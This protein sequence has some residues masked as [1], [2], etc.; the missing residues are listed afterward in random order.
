MIKYQYELIVRAV[1]KFVRDQ[2]MIYGFI[3]VVNT[4]DDMGRTHGH[5]YY[6]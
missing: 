5:R 4:V 2:L 6:V 3:I 1:D